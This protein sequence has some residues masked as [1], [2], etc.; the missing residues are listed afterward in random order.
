MV[1]YE[2]KL[3]AFAQG[4]RLLR[5]PR[6][7]RDRADAFCDA[8]GS[9]R[10]RTLCALKDLE[11]G[12]YYFAGAS[13][14]KEL[15]SQGVILRRFGK[16]S[17][18]AAYELEMQLR[19]EESQGESTPQDRQDTVREQSP[20]AVSTGDS[21]PNTSSGG[22]T[23]HPT[24]FMIQYPDHYSAFVSINSDGSKAQGW[25][26]AEESRW[27]ERWCRAGVGGMVLERVRD[28]RPEAARLCIA[29]AWQGACSPRG[30]MEWM[31]HLANGSNGASGDESRGLPDSLL[32]LLELADLSQIGNRGVVVDGSGHAAES[33]KEIALWKH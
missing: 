5:L 14:L 28:E 8:C 16:E 24:V 22:K 17:G 21:Q 26:Y 23:A 11:S 18:R 31:P 4:K 6:P 15:A 1:T 20:Q 12:R 27:E 7:I 2:E 3:T 19:I 13:C 33:T 10:P 29:R 30:E 25:G 32:A 9:T